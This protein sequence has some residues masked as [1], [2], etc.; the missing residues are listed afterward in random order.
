LEHFDRAIQLYPDFGHAYYSKGL[1]L[2]ELGRTDEAEQVLNQALGLY[3]N[4]GRREWIANTQAQLE[5]I[6]Q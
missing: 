2:A 3:V 6:R 5:R 1:A 4:Q